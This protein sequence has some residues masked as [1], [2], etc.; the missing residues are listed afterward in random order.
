MKNTVPVW[1]FMAVIPATQEA[2]LGRIT[3][4]EQLGKN[5]MRPHLNQ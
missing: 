5:F 3:V 2:E 4:Q 1:W